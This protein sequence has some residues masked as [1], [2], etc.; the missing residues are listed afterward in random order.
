MQ[1]QATGAKNLESEESTNSSIG[2]VL[3][4]VDNLIITADFWSIEKENTIGLFGRGNHT[5]KDMVLR[6]KNGLNNCDTFVGNPQ[7]VREAPD[8]DITDLFATTGVCPFGDITYVADEYMNLATRT[9]EG[10]DIGIY[11]SLIHI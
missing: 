5:V 3:T 4:P 1:R 8:T 6:W 11:L 7:V 9:I 10:H 2:F